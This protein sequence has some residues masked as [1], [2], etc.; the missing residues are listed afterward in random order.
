MIK[1]MIDSR[2]VKLCSNKLICLKYYLTET[3]INSG[4]IESKIIYGIIVEKYN[5]EDEKEVYICSEEVQ[6]ISDELD[7]VSYI[8][9]VL[10]MGT[11]PPITLLEIIDEMI[12]FV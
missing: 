12:S 10:I 1:T 2:I 8:L 6:G 9:K 11:V 4:E 5:I 7:V 3:L